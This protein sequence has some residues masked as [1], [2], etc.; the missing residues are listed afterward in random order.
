[1]THHR[2]PTRR[3]TGQEQPGHHFTAAEIEQETPIGTDNDATL[4]IASDAA[5]AK[6]AL[7][8]LRR[9]AHTRELTLRK[10]IAALAIP[11][12]RNPANV[13]TKYTVANEIASTAKLLR[14]A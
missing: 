10:A 7:H 6:R 5:S 13:G 12:E 14:N 11:G 1:M 9:L 2:R 4:R 8:I 3:P